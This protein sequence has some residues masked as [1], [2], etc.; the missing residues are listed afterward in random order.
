MKLFSEF[1]LGNITLKNRVVMAPMTR[2]R[3]INNTP[4]SLMAEYYKQR[5]GAGLIVTEG[6]SPSPNG[7]GYARIPGLFSNEQVE[8]WKNITSAVHENGGKIFAQIMHTGRVSHP[9]NLP[10]G[11]I[12]MAPSAVALSGE[13]WTDSNGMQAYPAPKEMTAEEIKSTQDEYVNAAKNAIEAGFDGVELHGAN[14]YL[15]DQFTNDASNKRTDEYGGSN[16]NRAKFAIEVSRKVSE[17]IGA[18]KTGIRLSP[19]GAF[20]DMT[21]FENLEDGFEYLSGELGK[22]DLAYL[23]IVDHSSAGAP[24]VTW[25][26]KSKIKNAFGGNIILSGGYDKETGERHLEENKGELIAWGKQ[27]ISNPDLVSR[28]SNDQKLADPAFDSFYTP[29]DKG[30]T[31][32]P[33]FE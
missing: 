20:N 9:D 27:F 23:H 31:D 12:M 6:V 22:L 30:Y 1:K 8:G 26:V 10:E 2:C 24:E 5:S 33:A 4:N 3:A 14:G 25:S 29:D 17:A 13:M 16:Q 21:I 28:L 18:D 32:Y 7:L 11:A 19:Y 15:I